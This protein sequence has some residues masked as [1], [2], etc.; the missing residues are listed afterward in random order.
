M[1]KAIL[2]DLDDTLLGNSM[3]TFMPAYFQTLAHSV[4]HLIPPKRLLSELMSATTL[5][6]VWF[7]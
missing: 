4:A 3:E 1:L 6:V 5:T 2:F 7:F